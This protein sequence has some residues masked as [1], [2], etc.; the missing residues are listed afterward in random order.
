[1]ILVGQRE[2]VAAWVASRIKTMREPPHKDFEAV[3]VV[4]GGEI[5]GGVIYCEYREIAPGEHDIR[6]HCAGGPG[7][8]TRTS[9]RALFAYPFQQLKCIRVTGV[10]ARG[11]RRALDLNKRLGFQIEGCIRDGYGAGKDGLLM[12]MLRRDCRWI[13]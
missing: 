10:V 9:L 13:S 5:I 7:W 1:M 4:K 6:M 3:G 11:N 2:L 12:G 8:L